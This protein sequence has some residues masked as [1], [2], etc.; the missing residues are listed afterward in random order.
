MHASS[1]NID[2]CA[3]PNLN[4]CDHM[5]KNTVPQYTCTCQPGYR[6]SVDGHSCIDIDECTT[7]IGNNGTLCPYGQRCINT[8]GSYECKQLCAPGLRE[9]LLEDR[10]DGITIILIKNNIVFVFFFLPLSL[11]LL[12]CC[13]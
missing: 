6:L 13:V 4:K 1:C 11:S 12:T 9:N 3:F 8:P 2:E 7:V 5:C 10:C